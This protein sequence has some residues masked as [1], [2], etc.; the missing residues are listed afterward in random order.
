MVA[1][2][3]LIPSPFRLICIRKRP[4]C[5]GRASQGLL[6]RA[7][8]TSMSSGRDPANRQDLI[9]NAILFLNDPKVQTSTFASKIQFL[10]SKGLNESEIQESLSRAASSSNANAEASGSRNYSIEAARSRSNPY[11]YG[12]Q[13]GVVPE[14]PRRDWRDIFVSSAWRLLSLVNQL[15]MRSDHGRDIWRCRIWSHSTRKSE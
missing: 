12:Y 13:Y 4:R 7:R 6:H 8:R 9:Q 1:T 14:P 15:T 11:E 2:C 10:E 3:N 5:F